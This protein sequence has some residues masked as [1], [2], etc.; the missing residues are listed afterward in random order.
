MQMF[1]W[2]LDSDREVQPRGRESERSE[3]GIESGSGV[4]ERDDG[5]YGTLCTC[6]CRDT[7]WG[8]LDFVLNLWKAP[9]FAALI[10]AR[11][12]SRF[13]LACTVALPHHYNKKKRKNH[14]CR[15]SNLHA[16]STCTQSPY[17][18]LSPRPYP[19]GHRDSSASCS[20]QALLSLLRMLCFEQHR[21]TKS[22]SQWQLS[23]SY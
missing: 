16:E 21:T 15:E 18:Y 22:V 7:T 3:Q 17:Q 12:R 5:N 14:P 13:A 23:F 9:T 8:W 11:W 19:L 20:R 4:Y 6:Y 10:P 1:L 2:L